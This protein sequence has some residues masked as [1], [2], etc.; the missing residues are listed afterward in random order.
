MLAFTASAASTADAGTTP[1]TSI[2]VNPNSG[3]PN[4]AQVSVSGKG[5]IAN[6]P[7]DIYECAT[8][9]GW[10]SNCEHVGSAN[11][12]NNGAFGPVQVTVTR[13]FVSSNGQNKVCGQCAVWAIS[14][15]DHNN[16][17]QKITFGISACREP[18]ITGTNGPDDLNGTAGPDVIAT[19]DGDDIV[20]G[21][22]GNDVICTDGGDDTVY[23][24]AGADR[25]YTLDGSDHAYGDAGNDR[26]WGG[27]DADHL[28][29]GDGDDSLMGGNGFDYCQ[30]DAGADTNNNCEW[31]G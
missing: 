7:V 26:I 28:F 4:T 19:L 9:G 12:N 11:A 14:R 27:D 31:T 21:L 2:I 24:G 6:W 13:T 30:G 10:P 15:W 18:T 8:D 5:F 17:S 25:I 22:G 3:L 16:A 23:G 20:H 1:G 29:G